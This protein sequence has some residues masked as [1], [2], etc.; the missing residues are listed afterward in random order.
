MSAAKAL[1]DIV[2]DNGVIYVIDTVIMPKMWS[3]MGGDWTGPASSAF[4]IPALPKRKVFLC[5]WRQQ[6][7]GLL[8]AFHL[9]AIASRN[10]RV[11]ILRTR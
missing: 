11:Q 7:K 5:P 2:C 9:P 1:K 8:Y 10:Q 3:R 6:G 4:Q